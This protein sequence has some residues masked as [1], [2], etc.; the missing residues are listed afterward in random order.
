[1]RKGRIKN[2]KSSLYLSPR[3]DDMSRQ[4]QEEK[5]FKNLESTRKKTRSSPTLMDENNREIKKSEKNNCNS[6]SI[7]ATLV[8]LTGMK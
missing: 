4:I 8:F 7:G 6:N 2:V 1:L 5:N 3:E